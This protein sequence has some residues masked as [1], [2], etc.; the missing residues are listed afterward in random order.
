MNIKE[1]KI[2][3]IKPYENNPRNNEAA[4]QYVKNSIE[5]FGFKVPIVLDKNNIIVTGHTRY[6]A[7]IELG[8]KKVPCLIA[9]DLTEKQIQAFRIADNKTQEKASW[10]FDKLTQEILSLETDFNFTDYGFG[11]F[12]LDVLRNLTDFDETMENS[13]DTAEGKVRKGSEINIDEYSDSKF[14]C[15]C[16]KC[17]FKFNME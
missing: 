16:P 14:E 5:Q 15:Q 6:Q 11:E 2:E 10:D 7:A 12:E 13:T 17:G 9:D 8:M 3:E 1:I 4:V